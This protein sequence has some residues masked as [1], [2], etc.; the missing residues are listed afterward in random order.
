M[1]ADHKASARDDI[2]KRVM[3]F[4]ENQAKLQREREGFYDAVIEKVRSTEWNKFVTPH[5]KRDGA[6]R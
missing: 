2:E 6:G 1:T 5:P 4:R 3:Q